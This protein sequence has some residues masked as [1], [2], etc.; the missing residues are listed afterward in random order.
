MRRLNDLGATPIY[1]AASH[2]GPIEP[3]RHAA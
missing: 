1:E 2:D 3:A